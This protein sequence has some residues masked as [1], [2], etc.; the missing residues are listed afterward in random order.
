MSFG[1]FFEN[2][3]VFVATGMGH[4][5]L[6]TMKG[7]KRTKNETLVDLIQTF[8]FFYSFL[9]SFLVGGERLDPSSRVC[10][11][12]FQLISVGNTPRGPI[13]FNWK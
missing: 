4:N 13:T 5:W 2:I 12:N 10:N 9:F 11:A 6:R 7:Q 3:Q 1:N 8:S